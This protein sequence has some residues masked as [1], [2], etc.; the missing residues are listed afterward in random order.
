MRILI[1]SNLISYTYNFRL[2]LIEALIKRKDEVIIASDNDDDAKWRKLEK[3]CELIEVPFDGKN[4]EIK[5]E[6]RLI[7]SYRRIINKVKPEVVLSFTIKM[8]LY[9]G[10]V[11]GFYNI[12]YIPM[13]TGLGE[14]EK[15]G[16]LKALLIILHKIVMPRAKCVIFQNQSNRETFENLGIKTKRSIV[17]P[18]SGINLEKYKPQPWPDEE[19]MVFTFIGRLT[20]AKGI[21]EFLYAV[22]RLSSDKI[23]FSAAGKIDEEYKEE[24]KRLCNEGKLDYRG[25]VSDSRELLSSSNCLVLPT[26]HPEGISNVILEACASARPV[27]CTDRTGC[28]EIVTNGYNGVFCLPQNK[29]NLVSVI[30]EFA[31][32]PKARMIEMGWNGRRTV[33]E[34]FDRKKVV[35]SYIKE[36]EKK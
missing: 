8:N 35:D 16:K 32:L 7:S 13:I 24:V 34:K 12:P 36:L 33:E 21:E 3:E 15:D 23:K 2:E 11:S 5:K 27:I 22:N 4:T 14:L 20:K 19:R 17:V 29:D 31:T 25:I 26:F 18:G 9:G 1:L 6:L 28:R 10:L 30:S